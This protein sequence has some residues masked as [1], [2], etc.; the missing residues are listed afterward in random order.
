MCLSSVGTCRPTGTI[1]GHPPLE[2]GCTKAASR[3][4][5]APSVPPY[6]ESMHTVES[7]ENAEYQRFLEDF[8]T[9]S[10][11]QTPQWGNARSQIWNYEVLGIRDSTGALVAATLVKY[12]NLP[13]TRLRFAYIPQGPLI[14]WTAPDALPQLQA[15]ASHLR[16]KNIFALR[17][18]PPLTLRSWHADT[19]KKGLADP[20]VARFDDLTPDET[21]PVGGDIARQLA[22]LGWK[23]VRGNK[24]A[25]A[26]QPRFNFHLS[27]EGGS[28]L[29][30]SSRMS[31][32]WRKNIRKA[33]R[34]G[35]QVHAGELADLDEVLKICAETADRNHF[36][37]KPRSYMESVLTTLTI[38]FPGR[39]SF[40]IVRHNG[41]V[42]AAEATA[43]IGRRVQGI[44]AAT[45]TFRPEVRPSNALYWELIRRA[46]A[47]GVEV[48]DIG[49]VQNTLDPDVPSA[50]LV[51]FKAGMGA[52][53]HEYIGVW[54]LPLRPRIYTAFSS[55]LALRD[56]A[57]TDATQRVR[58][59]VARLG[60]DSRRSVKADI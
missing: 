14:D 2:C 19:V 12:K 34:A 43:Q 8:E 54:D 37:A 9:A 41:E 15:L 45:S 25:E 59:L 60:E 20:D 22:R 5:V 27:L 28:E 3:S 57:Q 46:V 16:A 29:A 51:H 48:F 4:R 7:L 53:A 17:I 58:D 13:G 18:A 40:D 11:Q 30:V 6:S 39:I 31:K 56:L 23:E 35:V 1:C 44:V 21:N 33:E 42:L 50:G 24:E 38:D 36:S 26:S 47:N 52:D 49:G 10:Y 55:L 32:T